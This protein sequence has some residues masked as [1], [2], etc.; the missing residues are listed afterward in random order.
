VCQV[1]VR[2]WAIG[3][4]MLLCVPQAS[5]AQGA[6]GSVQ[7]TPEY[8]SLFRQI[9]DDPTNIDATFKFAGAATKLGDYEAAIGAL[10]RILFFNPNLPR[11]KLQ[12]GSLY[13]KLGSYAMARNYLEQARDTGSADVAAEA[14]QFIAE[15]DRRLSPQRWNV[16]AQTGL[17]YQT[18]ANFGPDGANI[19][20]LGQNTTINSQFAKRADWNWFALFGVNYSYDLRHGNEDAVE[21]GIVGYYAKQFTLSQFNFGLVEAQAGPRFSLPMKGATAKAYAIGTASSLADSAYFDGGGAGASIRFILDNPALTLIEPFAEYRHRTFHDSSNFTT[22]HQQTGG[23][24]TLATRAEGAL[25]KDVRWF[26]RIAFDQNSTDKTLYDFNSYNRWS[27]EVGIPISFSLTLNET[28]HQFILT[29]LAGIGYANYALPY[30]LVDP[31]IKR[32]DREWR[33]GAL[34]DAQIYER[35]GVRM[36]VQYSQTNSNLINYDMNN[37]SISFGPTVRF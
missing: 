2:R 26:G 18:N 6:A 19:K 21:A 15:L 30:G 32:Q 1:S 29:P 33:V 27:A 14:D 34:L 5:W 22:S 35:Y 11:V 17:R 20:S 4:A 16:F 37:L 8:N 28:P 12:L 24:L 31:N 25:L 23:L 7:P 10:E 3:V 9:F 13:F 36:Q